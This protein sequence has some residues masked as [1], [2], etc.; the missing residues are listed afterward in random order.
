MYFSLQLSV[1]IATLQIGLFCSI[2][3]IHS[4]MYVLYVTLQYLNVT[5]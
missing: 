1:L 4:I 2:M 5:E 3:C